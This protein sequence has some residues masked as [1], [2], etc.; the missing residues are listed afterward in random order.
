MPVSAFAAV[1]APNQSLSLEGRTVALA[2]GR[3]LEELAQMLEREGATT[4]RRP[5]LSI[6]DSPDGARVVVWLHELIAG[7]F[8]HVV[9]LTGEGLRRLLGFA[10]REEIR[11]QVIAALAKVRLITR[12]HKPVQALKE[13]GL[14]PFK[15]AAVPTTDGVIDVLRHEAL[16]GAQVGVQFYCDSNPPLCDYLNEAGARV[17]PVLPYVYAAAADGEQVAD[18]IQKLADGA[19]DAIIFTSSPQVDR[20]F[21]VAEERQLCSHLCRGLQRVKVAAVGPIVK[22]K[23]LE[24]KVR[25]DV[26]PEQGFVM[27][28]LVHQLKRAL[29]R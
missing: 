9:L 24:K 28:N 11:H 21:E 29:A 23:L 3:Q 8:T 18:L 6:L 20:L 10:E 2:E 7:K 15:V 17:H 26:V 12:G 22:E 14:V 19:V 16:A 1:V 27:K 13:L 5:M 4:L 25:V